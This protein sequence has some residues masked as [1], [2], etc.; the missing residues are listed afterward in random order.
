MDTI[1]LSTPEINWH[2]LE[3]YSIDF[4]EAN[5]VIKFSE[6]ETS[7]DVAYIP[8]VTEDLAIERLRRHHAPKTVRFVAADPGD[9][10]AVMARISS[11]G[12]GGIR[13]ISNGGAS[14]ALDQVA[15]DAPV[16]NLVNSLILDA[17]AAN[18]SD[19]HVEVDGAAMIVRYRID[20]AL[21]ITG[22]HELERFPAVASRI[23][24][25][26]NL[27]ILETRRPQDGRITVTLGGQEIHLRV[28]IVP[29]VSGESLVLRLFNRQEGLMGPESLGFSQEA[30][31][32]IRVLY[33]LPYGLVLATGPTGSGKTTTLSTFLA[34]IRDDSKKIITLEDP[35]EY[36]LPGIDQ[37]PVREEIGMGFGSLLRRVLRQ[38]PDIIMVGEIRDS[39]TAELAIRAALTGH[40]V[41]ATLHTNDAPS[42]IP[43]LVDMG[44][45]PY[46]V[47]AVLQGVIAQRLVRTTCPHCRSNRNPN[48]T[49]KKLMT[50]WKTSINSV[51]EVSGCPQCSESG[52]IGRTAIC[53]WFI[54]DRHLEELIVTNKVS[55]SAFESKLAEI[56]YAPMIIDG[57]KKVEKNLT[58]IG[59]IRQVLPS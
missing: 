30:V 27:N 52:Y 15:N 2:I 39:E 22:R 59:E 20:G 51:T 11:Q 23:K 21:R 35:V 13:D 16:V 57:L 7:V 12:E 47:G 28:S 48:S 54:S 37:I 43:R 8:G 17:L 6:N 24:I 33:R 45:P 58:T 1:N 46:M 10:A 55:D 40:L 18:A 9:F 50:K 5:R 38:D 19:I 34:E 49:E 32:A 41:F 3:Q 14:T 31:A 36:I 53:E 56:G 4:I 29:L 25:M 42:A 44:I 26:A